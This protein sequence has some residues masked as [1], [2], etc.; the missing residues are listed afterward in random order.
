M[1]ANKS[2]D[3]QPEVA[4]RS[5][6]HRAGLRFRVDVRPE[7]TLRCKADVV[8]RSAHVCVFVDGCFWHGCPRHFSV[9]KTNA[10]WWR[11]KIAD[12]E[13]RDRRKTVTLAKRGW[14]VLRFWEHQ[15]Q[16]ELKDCVN[17]VRRA[18]RRNLSER[19]AVRR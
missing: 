9:P 7:A 17:R 12:N 13:A 2:C 19:P 4:L 6:L 16:S 18:I 1:R 10:A 8:F 15:V 11:E 3:T 5:A 14:T